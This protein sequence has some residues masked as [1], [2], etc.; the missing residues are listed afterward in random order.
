[1]NTG[2]W[3]EITHL[4]KS[5]AVRNYLNIRGKKGNQLSDLP[6]PP[7]FTVQFWATSYWFFSWGEEFNV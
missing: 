2:F 4:S 1:M 5:K 7:K 6:R 3:V